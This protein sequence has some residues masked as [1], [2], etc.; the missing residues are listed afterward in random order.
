MYELLKEF[1]VKAVAKIFPW[2]LHWLYPPEKIGSLI[3][4]RIASDSDG[5]EFWGHELPKARAWIQITNLSP[6][7]L[8]LDRAFGNFEY[9]SDLERYWHLKKQKIPPAS[10][11]RIQV[12]ATLSASHAAII[13]RLRSSS[14]SPVV[15]FDGYFTCSVNNVHVSRRM[16]TTH[17]R[18]VN[19]NVAG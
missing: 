12:E 13:Q 5:I 1:A 6:F 2:A 8:E 4:I 11:A 15:N 9:G 14:P 17:H 3:Q 18:L 10:E 19:F 16:Q 7:T